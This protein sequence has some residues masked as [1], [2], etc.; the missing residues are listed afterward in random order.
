MPVAKLR[1]QFAVSFGEEI[2][3]ARGYVAQT[4][5]DLPVGV[6]PCSEVAIDYGTF[7]FAAHMF[8]DSDGVVTGM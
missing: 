1:C 3:L 2:R 6:D 4:G 7:G 8:I 5:Y